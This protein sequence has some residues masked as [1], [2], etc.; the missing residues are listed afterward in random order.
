MFEFLNILQQHLI[1]FAS[2]EWSLVLL[3]AISFTE[4]IFFPIPPDPLMIA[5]GILHPQ[6]S[7]WLAA[8]VTTTSVLGGLIGH[9]LGMRFGRPLL[10]KIIPEDTILKVED[11]FN[12]YGIWAVILA[13]ITP[14]PYKVF[15]IAAG[16]LKYDRKSF[17]FA[18]LLGRGARY[19]VLGGLLY[20][21]GDSIYDIIVTRFEIYASLLAGGSI[22]VVGLLFA[23]FKFLRKKQ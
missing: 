9:W 21:Y 19:F 20:F 1:N 2:S 13:A 12:K 18:S 8:L 5:M 14:I 16:M 15:T 23:Y 4:S 17:I 7:L 10:N 11:W 6:S 3:S 22:V